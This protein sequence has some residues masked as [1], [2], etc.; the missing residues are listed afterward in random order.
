MPSQ[1]H[2]RLLLLL[3]AVVGVLVTLGFL[4]GWTHV[5]A[6]VVLVLLSVVIRYLVRR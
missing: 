3:L 1:K 2:M 6:G 5:L 4:G